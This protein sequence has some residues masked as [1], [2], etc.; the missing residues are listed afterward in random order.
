MKEWKLVIRL[1]FEALLEVNLLKR[2]PILLGGQS[3]PFFFESRYKGQDGEA[4]RTHPI[5]QFQ[6]FSI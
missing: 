4:L 6:T 2:V 5:I 3:K 1:S